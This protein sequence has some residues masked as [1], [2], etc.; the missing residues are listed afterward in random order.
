SNYVALGQL[1]NAER[2][3]TGNL[4]MA[5]KRQLWEVYVETTISLFEFYIAK[6]NERLAFAAI[7]RGLEKI[8]V[9]NT[10]RLQL[11]LYRRLVDHYRQVVDFR[12]SFTY[13]RRRIS[14]R[15]SAINASQ[16]ELMRELSV[17]Y[18]ADRKSDQIAR[19]HLMNTQERR[20][21]AIYFAGLVLLALVLLLIFVLLRRI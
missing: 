14:I 10:G 4:E 18:E 1:E 21:K 8:H 9:T 11:K 3:L 20:T 6:G 2:L 12:N 5:E 7:E 16:A 15:D 17:K 13:L 19:L